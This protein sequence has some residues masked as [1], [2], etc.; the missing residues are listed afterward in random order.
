MKHAPGVKENS[1]LASM[2]ETAI[3]D[4]ILHIVDDARWRRLTRAESHSI[5]SDLALLISELENRE[6][7]TLS[8]SL[9]RIIGEVR[10]LVV[11]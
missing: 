9:R 4:A 11:R 2:A 1:V 6:C 7:W 8:I 3:T 5:S 10:T